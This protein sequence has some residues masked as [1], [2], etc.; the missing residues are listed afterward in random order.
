[1]SMDLAVWVEE[2]VQLPAALPDPASWTVTESEWAFEGEGWQVLVLPANDLPDDDITTHFPNAK[3]VFYIS[4]EPM[5]APLEGYEFL[6]KTVRGLATQGHG[7]W[8]DP[9]GQVFQPNEGSFE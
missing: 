8:V 3:S 9:D 4:L 6:E 5:G 2:E 1:M 7:V